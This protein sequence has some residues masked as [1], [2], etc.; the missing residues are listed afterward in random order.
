MPLIPAERQRNYRE[1]LKTNNPELWRE[2]KQKK[3]NNQSET[4]NRKES[5][6]VY[7]Q[8]YYKL[9]TQNKN[10]K[11]KIESLR[12]RNDTLR[13]RAYRHKLLLKCQETNLKE[14]ITPI[15]KYSLETKTESFIMSL[16]NL[17]I[18]DKNRVRK[19]LLEKNV[20]VH[21][22][23]EAY[24]NSKTNA[25]R[26]TIKTIIKN[27][28]IKK[29]KMQTRF[30]ACIGLKGALRNCN[31]GNMKQ[32]KLHAL[33][34]IFFLQDDVSRATSGKKETKTVKKLKF[35]KDTYLII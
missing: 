27:T 6:R 14:N 2:L 10:L 20:L 16:N 28:M 33:I 34:E 3:S 17:T 23:Y 26:N 11:K 22:L 12:K 7:K 24:R 18:S 9:F 5:R 29:Y 21:S 15:P 25:E 8:K 31:R 13:K 35:R 30:T 4:K 32:N 19:E 1:R